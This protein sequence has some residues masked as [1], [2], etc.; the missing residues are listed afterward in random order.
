MK[1]KSNRRIPTLRT[2]LICQEPFVCANKLVPSNWHKA[3]R[4]RSAAEF[5]FNL[6]TVVKRWD[7]F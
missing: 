7:P 3:L 6:I 1:I 4:G 5:L 2:D